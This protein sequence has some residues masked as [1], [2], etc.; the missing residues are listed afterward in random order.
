MSKTFAVIHSFILSKNFK[1]D[2]SEI[3]Q[4]AFRTQN[5]SKGLV[6]GSKEFIKKIALGVQR[7]S[8]RLSRRF[9]LESRRGTEFFTLRKPQF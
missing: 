7:E 1:D 9:D 3:K 4:L 5:W 2:S 8:K 6:V